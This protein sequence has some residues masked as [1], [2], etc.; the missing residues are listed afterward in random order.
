MA[1]KVSIDYDVENDILFLYKKGIRPKGSIDIGPNISVDFAEGG[2]PVGLEIIGATKLLTKTCGI[3][4]TKTA[5]A[6]AKKAALRSEIRDNFIYIYYGVLWA[7]PK[8]HIQKH[9]ARGMIPV[10]Q[11]A[12]K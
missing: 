4:V 1:H 7:I 11:V 10:P 2:N 8:D 5:L 9:E 6:H 3:S 12:A